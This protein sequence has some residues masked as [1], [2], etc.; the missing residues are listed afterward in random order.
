MARNFVYDVEIQ[1][2]VERVWQA[3]TDSSQLTAWL[4][5][6]DF[7]PTVG[8]KFQF[9]SAAAAGSE[10]VVDCEVLD[11]TP[12]QRL[13]YRWQGGPMMDTT[14]TW[15]LT[16]MGGGTR[17]KATHAGFN[18][19][20]WGFVSLFLGSR[21]KKLDRVYLDALKDMLSKH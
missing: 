17:L 6:N 15:E 19:L 13:A 2:P 18:L 4:M 5:A 11:V 8:H 16:P 7:K 14:L 10:G 20:R 3:L 21:W 1:Q 9:H 12:Q